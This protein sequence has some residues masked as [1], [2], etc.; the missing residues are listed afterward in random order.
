MRQQG[1]QGQDTDTCGQVAVHRPIQSHVA[2]VRVA[3]GESLWELRK[4]EE[5]I[6]QE[7]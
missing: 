7:T 6:G 4:E 1:E 3:L 2:V 5:S